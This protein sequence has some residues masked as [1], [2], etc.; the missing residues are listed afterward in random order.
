MKEESPAWEFD[1]EEW[2]GRTHEAG[3]TVGPELV[4]RFRATV[5]QAQGEPA[6]GEP[7]PVGI[8]WCIA[9]PALAP[10][11]LGPDGHPRKGILMP[12]I[13]LPRRMWAGGHIEFLEPVRVGDTV[14][15]ASTIT[16][17]ERKKGRSGELC[18]VQVTHRFAVAGRAVL[19]EV[20]DIVYREAAGTAEKAQPARADPPSGTATRAENFDPVR[21][22]RY[23]AL[24]FNGHRIHYDFPYATQ[25]E[26]YAGLVVHGPL[27]ATLLMH[28]AQGELGTLRT[29]SFRG[30]SPL[31]CNRDAVLW[32]SRR[33]DG[34]LAL[35]IA[36]SGGAATMTASA[37]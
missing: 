18:F 34:G 17:I 8:H 21:L 36:E 23:S 5:L 15:R 24:T 12:P 4:A 20:Q 14:T 37:A 1:R 2:I 29:F 19:N 13:P 11:R 35:G 28:L 7:A 30:K 16:S 22:F 26:G 32:A 33:D 27:Q 6:Q 10:D 9:P 3:E 31:I 25:A